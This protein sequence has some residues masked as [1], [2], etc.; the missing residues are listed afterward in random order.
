[1][2]AKKSSV[3]KPRLRFADDISDAGGDV[4]LKEEKKKKKKREGWVNGVPP[5]KVK[6]VSGSERSHTYCGFLT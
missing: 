4:D 3:E 1:V 6:P 5:K 2:A